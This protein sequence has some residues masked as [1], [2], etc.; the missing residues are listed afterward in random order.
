MDFNPRIILGLLLHIYPANSRVK[1][2]CQWEGSLSTKAC[3]TYRPYMCL[4]F[5]SDSSARDK[6]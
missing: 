5:S 3:V 1:L 6:W 4:A 2:A